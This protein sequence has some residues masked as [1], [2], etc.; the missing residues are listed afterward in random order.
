MKHSTLFCCIICLVLSTSIYADEDCD[1]T[2]REAKTAYNAGEYS[3]AKKLYDY[4]VSICGASYGNASS[5]SQKCQDALNPKLTVSRS[6][7]SVGASSGSTNISVTSN[8]T[9]KLANTNSALF[10]VSKN[11]NSITINYSANPNNTSRSDYFDV[12]TTDGSKSV[13]VHVTQEPM[14]TT[15]F[16]T[17]SQSSISATASGLTETI[18]VSSNTTW[19]V[20]YPSATMYSV[21]RSGNTLTVTINANTSTDSRTDYFN[22]KTTDG[23]LVQKI[24]LSQQ[25]RSSTPTLSVS[26]TSISAS[27]SGTTEYITVTSNTTWE[28]QYPSAT[29]YS[30]SRSGNTLTVTINANTTTESR[31]DYFN[32]K[33]TDGTIVKKI[34]LSQSGRSTNSGT[35]VNMVI[36]GFTICGNQLL[37]YTDNALALTSLTTAIND[38]GKV[39]T[40]AIL[41]NGKGVVIYGSNGYSYTG[42]SDNY[43]EIGTKI[44][45]YHDAEERISDI[46]INNKGHYVIIRGS[47]GYGSNGL[48][49]AFLNK[50][51]EFNNASETILSVSLDNGDNWAIVTD[52]HFQASNS[53]DHEFMREAHDKYGRIESVCI[54]MKGIVVCC[55]NGVYFRGVPKQVVDKILDLANKGKNPK[56]V[57]FTDS[58]TCLITDGIETHTFYM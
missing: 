27:S 54:T 28:V 15:P 48:P 34:S 43:A 12:V 14:A 57:K 51:K 21:S 31:T 33:T 50:I 52:A 40:G 4:V 7:I 19:E 55:T 39:R 32:V 6:R 58:G 49:S 23:N 45:Q 53:S 18:T 36:N 25:G 41:E 35:Y 47:N 2:L 20:Q 11:G 3:K 24:S 42:L 29:M 9:W 17:V 13:R 16:L 38:W 8:R 26:K 46:T 10:T 22:V 30:V 56:V 44:K 37:D 5:W 1:L